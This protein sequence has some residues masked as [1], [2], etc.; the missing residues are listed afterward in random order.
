MHSLIVALFDNPHKAA[1]VHQELLDAKLGI[2]IA[3]EEVVVLVVKPNGDVT[4]NDTA[5]PTI[6][7]ALSGGFMGEL[8]GLILFNPALALIGGIAGIGVGAS[9]DALKEVGI[10]EAFMEDL[11]TELT[12]GSS[13]LFIRTGQED[14]QSIV[15]MLEPAAQQVLQAALAHDD[16]TKLATAL[17]ETQPVS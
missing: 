2:A 1:S 13:A 3:P 14:R 4:I 10:D 11:A 5:H 15:G 17:R 16:K 9:M 8:A 7:T 6:P 12:P